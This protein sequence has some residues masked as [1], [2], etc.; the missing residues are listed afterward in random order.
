MGKGSG[1]GNYQNERG[2][3]T[4]VDSTRLIWYAPCQHW[5]DNWDLL[6]HTKEGIPICPICRHV[7][8]Q[9]K[10]YQWFS[11]ID[12]YEANGHPGYMQ[13]VLILEL[14]ENDL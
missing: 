12:K 14:K 8:F 13:Q 1:L 10:A 6:D 7:G 11:D 9:I 2:Q 3:T 5:T 4:A